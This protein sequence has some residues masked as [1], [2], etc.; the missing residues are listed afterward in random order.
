MPEVDQNQRPMQRKYS[1]ENNTITC[2]GIGQHTQG[3]FKQY[4][5][6]KIMRENYSNPEIFENGDNYN[7]CWIAS[8]FQLFR[9]VQ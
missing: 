9:Q 4:S 5:I 7:L 2:I 8:W 6:G 1:W 3:S